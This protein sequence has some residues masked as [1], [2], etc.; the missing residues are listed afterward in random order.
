[1][2][3]KMKVYDFLNVCLCVLFCHNECAIPFLI[4]CNANII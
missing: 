4:W 3:E 1:M 2:N